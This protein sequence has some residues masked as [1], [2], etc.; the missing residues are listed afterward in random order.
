MSL[1]VDPTQV[2]RCPVCK[3]TGM[4]SELIDGD[5]NHTLFY[6]CKAC[7]GEKWIE[8]SPAP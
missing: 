2:K 3:G 7:Y 4:H 1:A 8:I 5:P 6:V